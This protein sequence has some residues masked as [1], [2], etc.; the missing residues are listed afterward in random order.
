MFDNPTLTNIVPRFVD[1]DKQSRIRKPKESS[2]S[3]VSKRVQH[4]DLYNETENEE[5]KEVADI[6]ACLSMVYFFR[7]IPL[8]HITASTMGLPT[9]AWYQET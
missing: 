7:P 2:H 8:S 9:R 6:G 5:F 4:E 3:T 1:V